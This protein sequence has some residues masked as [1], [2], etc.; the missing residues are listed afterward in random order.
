M[1]F[2]EPETAYLGQPPQT[3]TPF[4]PAAGLMCTSPEI[5]L[6]RCPLQL[7][8]L[9]QG[10]K[11]VLQAVIPPSSAAR[12]Q[13]TCTCRGQVPQLSQTPALSTLLQPPKHSTRGLGLT[14]P[15]PLQLVPQHTTGTTKDRPAQ[16]NTASPPVPKPTT[17]GPEDC[18]TL[19][20]TG[21]ISALL[22]RV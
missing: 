17:L 14:L 22:F 10:P 18:P 3:A 6:C 12:S 4:L 19:S 9:L 5:R 1:C 16:P 2:L 15:C 8:L 11:H 13:H 21:G 7:P 20:T